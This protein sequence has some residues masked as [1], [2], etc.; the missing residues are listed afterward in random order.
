MKLFNF[1]KKKKKT[2]IKPIDNQ[3]LLPNIVDE[4][5]LIVDTSENNII[6]LMMVESY[7]RAVPLR[8]YTNTIAVSEGITHIALSR[9]LGHTTALLRLFK[10]NKNN[11]LLITFNNCEVNR[12]SRLLESSRAERN[13]IT[14]SHASD[15]YNLRRRF[16]GNKDMYFE[17]VFIDCYSYINNGKQVLDNILEINTLHNNNQL[18]HI[19]ITQ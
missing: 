9:Q 6:Y 4:Y 15:I 1:L 17:Y 18:K 12:L 14:S 2:M 3:T 13:I 16:I 10:H 7:K 19:F 11:S 5:G 8:K